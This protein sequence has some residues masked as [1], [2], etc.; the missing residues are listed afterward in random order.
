MGIKSLI[1][2]ITKKQVKENQVERFEQTKEFEDENQVK[3]PVSE[4]Q[5]KNID[6]KDVEDFLR[7]TDP[8]L[9]ES[10]GEKKIREDVQ[11]IEY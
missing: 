9:G 3:V 5:V 1:E 10:H 11:Y 6:Q 7:L 8:T 2:K 4:D